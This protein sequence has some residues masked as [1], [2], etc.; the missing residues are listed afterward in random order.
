MIYSASS[1]YAWQNMANSAY[2]LNRHLFF[3]IIGFL[4]SV[5]VM[6]INYNRLK[7]YAKPLLI[8]SIVFLILLLIPGLSREIGG[9]RRWFKIFS[10]NFQPSEMAQIAMII[11][12]AEFISR[13]KSLTDDFLHGFL[14]VISVLGIVAGLILIQPDLGT[15]VALTVVILVMLFISG[16]NLKYIFSVI[17]LSLPALYVLIFSAPYRRARM[18]TFLNPWAD[19]EGK[20]FQLIQAQIALGSGGIFGSGLGMSKAKLSYLPAAHTDFI[21]SIIGEELGM[22]GTIGTILLFF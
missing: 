18:L 9:A 3:L 7:T 17:L 22:F 21:F 11:Y 14:P 12:V 20:G 5:F 19:P 13:K 8:I 4:L 1:I 6:G 2:Y 16:I 10:L 15:V